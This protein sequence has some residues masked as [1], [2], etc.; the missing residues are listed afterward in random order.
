MTIVERRDNADPWR[1]LT[2]SDSE[3]MPLAPLRSAA[4]GPVSTLVAAIGRRG[5]F[6]D[7]SCPR[8]PCS[9]PWRPSSGRIPFRAGR[10]RPLP[11]G[12]H[13]S[14]SLLEYAC[15]FPRSEEHTSELQSREYLVYR[16]LLEK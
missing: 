5:A 13:T 6:C 14:A 1:R 12:A 7:N 2:T 10:A 11:I 15:R 8:P 16:L 9:F 3:I 4:T